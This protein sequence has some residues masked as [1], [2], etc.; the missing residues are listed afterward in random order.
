MR[1]LRALGALT[2][3][4][5]FVTGPALA[6]GRFPGLERPAHVPFAKPHATQMEIFDQTISRRD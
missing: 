5:G 6:N 4:L 2:L 1:F 3:A